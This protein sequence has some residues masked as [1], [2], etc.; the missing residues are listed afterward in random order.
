MINPQTTTGL[1]TGNI[2]AVDPDGDPLTYT[3][4]GTPHNGGTV[5]IDQDGNFTYRPM[6]AMAAVGGTDQFTV[7]VSDEA[8]G[9]MCTA[10]WGC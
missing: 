3:V 4:I 6:N 10:C 9:S 5:E 8:A 7:V 2:G 1:I